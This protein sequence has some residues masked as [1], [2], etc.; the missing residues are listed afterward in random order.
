MSEI[1]FIEKEPWFDP[2]P[3]TGDCR[4]YPTYMMKDGVEYFLFNRREPEAEA[5]H[6]RE[7][8]ERKAQLLSNGGAFF[9]FHGYKRDPLSYLWNVVER[10]HTFMP[11]S[12][13]EPVRNEEGE[14]I[15]E[16]SCDLR[17]V[18]AA[19]HYRIYDEELAELVR[20]IVALIQKKDYE[21]ARYM[22]LNM[23]KH[24][25]PFTDIDFETG[26]TTTGKDIP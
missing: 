15:T 2:S 19:C 5:W 16:F 24:F 7:R 6:V 1:S 20:A 8:E 17:E 26:D 21:R 25:V 23:P 13:H 22:I 11:C 9:C 14:H 4:M 3:F 10:K 12:Y 18:S